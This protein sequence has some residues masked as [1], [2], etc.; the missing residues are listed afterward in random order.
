MI[1]GNS[2]GILHLAGI[3]E[4][5]SVDGLGGF[6]AGDNN[7]NGGSKDEVSV[8]ACIEDLRADVVAGNDVKS[9]RLGI[10][11][12]RREVGTCENLI[13]GLRI[14][15][16]IVEAVDR[17]TLATEILKIG[18]LHSEWKESSALSS[19]MSTFETPGN[20]LTALAVRSAM[21]RAC[22]KTVCICEA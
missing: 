17:S 15:L 18:E 1:K 12:T 11:Y 13:D 6:I 22:S 8:A 16:R 2:T 14:D 10:A 9:P 19:N 3:P 21:L 20:Y 5:F 7:E 4:N